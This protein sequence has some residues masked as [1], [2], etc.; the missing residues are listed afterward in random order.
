MN[1]FLAK[2]LNGYI[3]ITRDQKWGV[4]VPLGEQYIDRVLSVGFDALI[5]YVSMTSCLLWGK[6]MCFLTLWCNPLRSLELGK[7]GQR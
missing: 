7:I 3:C 6:T 4:P 2:G 5:G 1:G